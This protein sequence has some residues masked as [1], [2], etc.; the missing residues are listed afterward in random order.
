[1][2]NAS[3]SLII[4][5][6]EIIKEAEVF[7]YITRCSELQTVASRKLE[8]LRLEILELKVEAIKEQDEDFANLL[9]GYSC[10]VEALIAEI[11]MWLHLKGE[12][13]DKAWENLVTAQNLLIA[14]ART[15]EGF[16]HLVHHHQRLEMI[17]GLL[18]P[19]QVFVSSSM[20]IKHQ[21]CSICGKDYN[22]CEHLRGMPYM[23]EFC[24][25]V[26]RD[27]ELDH[28]AI[29]ENPADKYCRITNIDLEGG[30]RNRMTWRVV[31]KGEP[32][33][34]EHGE[35]LR[36]QATILRSGFGE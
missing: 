36:V 20:I 9:L 23:G 18:F 33:D 27:F 30:I 24:N 25:V 15:H 21:E 29:V 8:K 2:S 32:D 34:E 26:I 22:D 4:E 1:M 19:A 7:R 16:N 11:E 3:S 10:V 13:P 14:A 5:F 28:V 31:E 35:E 12:E 17:E 6:N